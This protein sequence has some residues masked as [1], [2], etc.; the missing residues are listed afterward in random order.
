MIRLLAALAFVFL[1]CRAAAGICLAGYGCSAAPPVL[2]TTVV[3]LAFAGALTLIW[4]SLAALSLIRSEREFRQLPRVALPDRALLAAQRL[5]L[6][7][8]VCVATA[9]PIAFCAGALRPQVVISRSAIT[10]LSDP[11]L[12]AVL[13]HEAS[14]Q[15]R[16]EPLRR[17]LRAAA[18]SVM[19]G[20]PLLRWWVAES[21]VRSEI[22]ADRAGTA[23]AGS[24]AVAGALITLGDAADMPSVA[25]FS[26]HLELRA[27]HILGDQLPARRP[28][29]A[30]WASS[31]FRLTV[32]AVAIFCILDVLL[33]VASAG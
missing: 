13:A 14:H 33:G 15:R 10:R 20:L 21:I 5:G 4:L 17:A 25:A 9:T 12:L 26:G 1:V 27:A 8:V 18:S 24:P 29:A 28:G 19:L 2:I 11:G 16:H 22:E 30:V 23:A 32:I 6:E 31:G 7:T 3:V